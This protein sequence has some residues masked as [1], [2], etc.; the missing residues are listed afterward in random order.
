MCGGYGLSN[1]IRT[2]GGCVIRVIIYCYLSLIDNRFQRCHIIIRERYAVEIYV[3][4]VLT[5]TV[6]K[7]TRYVIRQRVIV[8]VCACACVRVEGNK[9][10]AVRVRLAGRYE[11]INE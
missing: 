4:I 11:C 6:Y 10:A 2:V 7:S 5:S 1:T 8:C 9:V 3:F